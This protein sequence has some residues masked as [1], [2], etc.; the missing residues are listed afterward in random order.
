MIYS[1]P[2]D[3]AALPTSDRAGV[4]LRTVYSLRKNNQEKGKTTTTTALGVCS[5]NRE[6]RLDL[7]A[8]STS[9]W[10]G[11]PG[12]PPQS[13]GAGSAVR[14]ARAVARKVG[15]YLG[16]AETENIAYKR[17]QRGFFGREVLPIEKSGL[18]T[19]GLNPGQDARRSLPR[20]GIW[21]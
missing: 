10:P 21:R 3:T 20:M 13:P 19:V 5:A 15:G 1:F 17:S 7:P 4:R 18:R 14:P 11:V 16:M 2:D 12:W 9:A 6:F 8:T